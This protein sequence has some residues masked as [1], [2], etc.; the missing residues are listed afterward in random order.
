[1]NNNDKTWM[2]RRS[3]NEF[4]TNE[5]CLGVEAFVTFTLS[6]PEC[7]LNG[8]LRCPCNRKKC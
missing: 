4:L 2:Y 6:H 1:M 5:F 3:E 7:L 8:N